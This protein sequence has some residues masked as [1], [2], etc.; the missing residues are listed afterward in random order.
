MVT[1]NQTT[2]EI[3]MTTQN[4]EDTEGRTEEPGRDDTARHSERFDDA[5]RRIKDV[6]DKLSDRVRLPSSGAR[7]Q[8]S[9]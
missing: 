6:A 9:A 3:S 5:V 2:G 7:K 1:Q 8:G 4:P